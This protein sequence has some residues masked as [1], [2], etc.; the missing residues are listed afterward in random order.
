VSN[1]QFVSASIYSSDGHLIKVLTAQNYPTGKHSLEIESDTL[2]HGL[3]VIE[4]N[5]GDTKSY[6]KFIKI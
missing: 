6:L 4:I 2:P 1:N 3:Y 5:K